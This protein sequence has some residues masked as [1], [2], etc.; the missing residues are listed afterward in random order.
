MSV[1]D[2]ISSAQNR[3]DE[4]LNQELAKKLAYQNDRE[5][6][7]E[8]AKNLWNKDKNIQRDCIKVLYEIGYINPELVSNYVN[9]YLQLLSNKNNNL[10]WGGMIALFVIADLRSSEIF[11]NVYL[12]KKTI[13]EGSV[14]T[15]DSGIKVLSKIASINETYN[16]GI[17]PYLLE[18]LKTCRPKDVPQ[19]AESIFRAVNASNK[20]ECIKVLKERQSLFNKS[21]LSRVTKLIKKLEKG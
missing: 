14:I 8:I 18:H 9:E 5:N 17:F 11:E 20:T 1:L 7:E 13:K 2:K 21:Q 10:V 12:I 16:K 4:I 19:H 3:R 6:I 15:K